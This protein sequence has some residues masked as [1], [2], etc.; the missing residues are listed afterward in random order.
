[1]FTALDHVY[2]NTHDP[3]TLGI[4][5]A[6]CEQ[7]TIAAIYLHEYVLLQVVKLNKA[8]KTEHMDLS[9]VSGIMNTT[10]H[11]PKDIYYAILRREKRE[12]FTQRVVTLKLLSHL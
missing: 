5:I 11:S 4:K 6:L 8:F 12:V 9:Y 1:M 3:E 7:S 10:L 2:Q